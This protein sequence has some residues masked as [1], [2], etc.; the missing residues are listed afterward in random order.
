MGHTGSCCLRERIGVSHQSGRKQFPIKEEDI[1]QGS[2]SAQRYRENEAETRERSS[3]LSSLSDRTS[4]TQSRM[5]VAGTRRG[6][7]RCRGMSILTDRVKRPSRS[8]LL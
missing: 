5:D 1:E 2:N 7:S 4:P 8:P 3:P 6:R